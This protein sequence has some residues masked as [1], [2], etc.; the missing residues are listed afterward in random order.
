M[1]SANAKECG[2]ITFSFGLKSLS[3]SGTDAA[4]SDGTGLPYDHATTK[5][6][7]T[8]SSR[9][10]RSG[11]YDMVHVE[12]GDYIMGSPESEEGRTTNECQHSVTVRSFAIGKYEVTHAD[13]QKI[14]K[15]DQPKFRFK[16]CDDCPVEGVSWNEIQNFLKKLNTKYPGKNY[17]LPSGEEWEYAA[18]GGDKS[19]GYLYSGRNDLKN[20][21][22]YRDNF[23]SKIPQIGNFV[24]NELGIYDM[25]GNVYEWCQD[26]YKP[27]P[28][29]SGIASSSR[30]LRGGSWLYAARFCRVA[31]R[32][33]RSSGVVCSDLC[34][35]LVSSPQ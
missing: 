31:S 25:S 5:S 26:E 20:V 14:M 19:K 28:G 23:A 22:W 17:R 29:C 27:Y 7:P 16:G 9:T 1:A 4:P 2:T 34:F 32:L 15:K 8:G 11:I 12:G 18:R 30:V 3:D 21:A 24:A 6:S 35:R 10:R 33:S 13:W